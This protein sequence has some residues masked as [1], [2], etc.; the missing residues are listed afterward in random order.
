MKIL[1]LFCV[2]RFI[3]FQVL[4]K[5]SR[6]IINQLIKPVNTKKSQNFHFLNPRIVFFLALILGNWENPLLPSDKKPPLAT[7]LNQVLQV[8]KAHLN[9]HRFHYGTQ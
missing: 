5:G 3:Y 4:Q 6:S 9:F 8:H 2:F 1:T 7:P